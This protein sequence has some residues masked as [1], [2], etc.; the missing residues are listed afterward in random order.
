MTREHKLALVVGFT[1]ILFVGIL[2]SD[3]LAAGNRAAEQLP[4]A[5]NADWVLPD[6]LEPRASVRLAAPKTTPE[7]NRPTTATRT[8]ATANTAATVAS[9][10]PILTLSPRTEPAS[11]GRMLD[12]P[13]TPSQAVAPPPRA[14][15]RGVHVIA[16]GETL[17]DISQ[18]HFGTTRRWQEIARLNNIDDPDR[19]RVGQKLRL[20]GDET[21]RVVGVPASRTNAN[22]HK[23]AEGE[24][25]IAIARAEL[26]ASDRWEEIARL[27]DIDDPSSIRVG[28]TLVLPRH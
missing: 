14:P 20:P 17:Q 18:A 2:L 23:V 6:S 21:T 11:R 5:S 28:Q 10:A 8:V 16:S 13:T 7:Q 12:T 4:V 27:N 15:S 19:V 3:H 26:G 22:R 25:L 24:T 9:N 1:L